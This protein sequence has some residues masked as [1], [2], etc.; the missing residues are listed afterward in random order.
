MSLASGLRYVG[1]I[2]NRVAYV[3]GCGPYSSKEK[4]MKTRTTLTT[5]VL[6]IASLTLVA[7]QPPPYN[8][9]G[10]PQQ[11]PGSDQTRPTNSGVPR[12]S[13]DDDPSASPNAPS[14]S[15][16]A[17]ASSA[18]A[19]APMS[20]VNGELVN[21]LDSKTA[22]VGD[23]IVVQTKQAVKTADGTE[24]PKGSKL[25]GKVM[26]VQHSTGGDNSQLSV[27]FDHVELQDGQK[28][29]VHSQIQAIGSPSGAGSSASSGMTGPRGN[30]PQ[31][32]AGG[33]AS[34]TAGATGSRGSMPEP[35]YSDASGPQATAAPG[36][37][38]SRTG[39]IAIRTTSVPGVLVANNVPGTQD[40]RMGEAS[41]ILLGAKQDIKLE[42]GTQM[43]VAISA[44]NRGPQ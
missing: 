29:P 15:S 24:I 2:S 44:A 16:N 6:A 36:T 12:Y 21:K 34:D 25:V 22:S 30:A 39:N 28:L 13:Q 1:E 5:T 7:Q 4:F 32:G 9:Q 37:L 42:G 14:K 19:A 26:D 38:V 17:E 18:E 3:C 35:A 40:P 33:S 43:V 11:V 31:S 41:S 23:S 20:P 27:A 8:R 10:T